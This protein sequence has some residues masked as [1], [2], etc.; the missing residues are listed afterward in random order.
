VVPRLEDIGFYTLSDARVKQSSS[1]SPLWRCELIL[2]GRCNFKCP[3][4]RHVGGRDLEFEQA[5]AVV[6]EWAA[7]G[8]KNVRFS[9]GE[10]TLWP[11]LLELVKLAKSLG[12]ERIAVSTNGSSDI[13]VYRDLLSAGVNDLSI[14]LDACC[15]EDGD[16]MAGGIKGAW[17]TVV[18]N[19]RTLSKETY[20]TVGVVLT[21]QNVGT[22]NDIIRFAHDLGVADIRIIPAAQDGNKLCDVHVDLDLQEA[23]PILKYRIRNLR[24]GATVRGINPCDSKRCGLVLDDMAVMRGKHYPCIIYM[25]ERGNPIGIVGPNMRKER[26]A[27]STNHDTHA[28]PICKNNCLDVCVDY[29]RRFDLYKYG[30]DTNMPDLSERETD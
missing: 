6:R 3:Y 18:E 15:A 4:C 22:V 21:E 1:T 30:H 23:H 17:D 9:G 7:Q 19:I 20:V 14:S 26:E 5:A 8:L 13:S 27:W 25:R 16:K 2:T 29:N 28:D 10:P 24:M 12:V 11:G